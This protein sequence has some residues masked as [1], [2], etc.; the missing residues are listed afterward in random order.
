MAKG[1]AFAAKLAHELSTEGKVI[2]SVCNTEIKK[3]KLVRSRKSKAATWAPKYQ[4]INIC[5]CNEKDILAGKV[6]A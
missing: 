1:K 4:L 2:C 3:I 5:K 6:D